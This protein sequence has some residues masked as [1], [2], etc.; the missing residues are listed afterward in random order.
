M[1]PTFPCVPSV[2]TE[3]LFWNNGDSRP[4]LSGFFQGLTS[5]VVCPLHLVRYI[6]RLKLFILD[7]NLCPI[8]VFTLKLI[9]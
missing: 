3:F 8:H 6:D 4:D 7:S 2:V 1:K 5:L 9:N